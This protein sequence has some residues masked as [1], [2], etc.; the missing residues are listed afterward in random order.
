MNPYRDKREH[1]TTQENNG[2]ECPHKQYQNMSVNELKNITQKE[3]RH[4]KYEQIVYPQAERVYVPTIA[5]I[6]EQVEDEE[7]IKED[8]K[9]VAEFIEKKRRGEK[10]QRKLMVA[11]VTK[12][13]RNAIENLIGQ[14]LNA[15]YHT[16]D[17]NEFK[18]IEKR[19]G[20]AGK[21][22]KSMAGIDDYTKIVDVLHNFQKVDF[23]RNNKGSIE[24]SN[25]TDKNG[26]YAPLI[27]FSMFV[28][29]KYKIVVEAI[30][31]GKGQ[32]IKVIS[33][34]S[35]KKK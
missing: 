23:V 28:G 14:P 1:F 32:D 26:K 7:E 10:T 16:L 31:D 33:S 24:Y 8:K 11:K 13:A 34:Y 12:R 27:E 20:V 18:H 35:H 9:R 30:T 19:H 22:D 25:L 4:T 3:Y 21:H 17:I 5:I 15:L 29:D 6:T 2:G